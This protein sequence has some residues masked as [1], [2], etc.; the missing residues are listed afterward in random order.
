[1]KKVPTWIYRGFKPIISVLFRIIYRPTIIN[2]EVIPKEGPVILA[3]NHKDYFDPVFIAI[4]TKR[5]VHFLAKAVLF[6]GWKGFFMRNCGTLP[7]QVGKAHKDSF[8]TAIQILNQGKVIGI[9]PEGTRNLTS[10][11]M[12]PFRKGAVLLAKETGSKIIPFAIRGEYKIFGK[13][14][15]EYG[16][17][18]DVSNL[19]L[20]EANEL[21]TEKVKELLLKKEQ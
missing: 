15:L 13:L 1:M 18:L 12:L 19:T 14:T 4:S 20:E 3:G 8:K 2:K 11:L 6:K 5:F 17:L 9:F 7:V 10:N 16:E 21:L